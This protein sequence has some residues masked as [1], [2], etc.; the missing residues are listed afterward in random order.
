M[1]TSG[2]GLRVV[3]GVFFS[4]SKNL[5]T[6]FFPRFREQYRTPFSTSVRAANFNS[7]VPLRPAVQVGG[8]TRSEGEIS[9]G[10]FAYSLLRAEPARPL[11]VADPTTF[12]FRP[13]SR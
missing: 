7:R 10:R 12:S 9:P 8:E 11:H 5:L 1:T 4:V 13:R 6:V 3:S 2:G